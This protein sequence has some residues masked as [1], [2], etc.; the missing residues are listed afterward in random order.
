M[1][2][3]L[4]PSRAGNGATRGFVIGHIVPEAAE[5]GP[6]A[7][8]KEG[9]LITIDV[10]KRRLDIDI[11][12]DEMRAQ[13]AEWNPP[14]PRYTGGV[15]AKYARRGDRPGGHSARAEIAKHFSLTAEGAI[16]S[17]GGRYS[18][19][20]NVVTCPE[21]EVFRLR[22]GCTRSLI[23]AGARSALCQNQEESKHAED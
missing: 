23:A 21:Q 20:A 13:L 19:I 2:Y 11:E 9:D 1:N 3:P 7:A 10:D 16:G 4:F 12:P 18:K 8:V 14:P 5:R 17:P 6:I 22:A 15:F